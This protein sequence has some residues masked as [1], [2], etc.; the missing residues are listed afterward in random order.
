MQAFAADS[1]SQLPKKVG[2]HAA[3]RIG[4]R[5]HTRPLTS[6]LK[7]PGSRSVRADRKWEVS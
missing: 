5:L 1:N 2:G 3:L 4:E 6:W 7:I